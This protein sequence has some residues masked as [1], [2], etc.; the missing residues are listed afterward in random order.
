MPAYDTSL[1]NPPAPVARVVLRNPE[2]GL[3]VS[4]VPMLLDSGADVTLI[5]QTFVSQLGLTIDPGE[6]Y[7]L[8]GFDGKTSVA[9]AIRTD[10]MFLKRIFRGRF[11][12][13]DQLCGILGRDVLNHLVLVLDGPGLHWREAK[14]DAE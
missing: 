1:F 4:D 11:L 2:N 14:Q 7:E 8:M 13:T 12:V 3:T 9:P 5:P 10:L 6:G